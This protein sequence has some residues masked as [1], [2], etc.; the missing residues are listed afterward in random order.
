[1]RFVDDMTFLNDSN[2]VSESDNSLLAFQPNIWSSWGIITVHRKSLMGLNSSARTMSGFR[3]TST[4]EESQKDFTNSEEQKCANCT[5]LSYTFMTTVQGQVDNLF[6]S[7]L[8]AICHVVWD[9]DY[10]ELYCLVVDTLCRHFRGTIWG[11]KWP[12]ISALNAFKSC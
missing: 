7:S 4:C 5:I 11:E 6:G 10:F 9:Y 1:M 12:Y 3:A 2:G 8:S